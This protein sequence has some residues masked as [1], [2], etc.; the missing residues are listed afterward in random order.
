MHRTH[1][2][3]TTEKQLAYTQRQ[4]LT[5]KPVSLALT[6]GE[7]CWYCGWVN[8]QMSWEGCRESDKGKRMMKRVNLSYMSANKE[9]PHWSLPFLFWWNVHLSKSRPFTLSSR[10]FVSKLLS[11]WGDTKWNLNRK[12]KLHCALCWWPSFKSHGLGKDTCTL[13]G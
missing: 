9:L 10:E 5:C 7:C 4:T 8:S 12:Q 1:F 13:S 3:A 11:C 2:S 6:S